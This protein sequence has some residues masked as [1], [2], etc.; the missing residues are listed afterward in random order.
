M[1]QVLHLYKIS[2]RENG[3]LK[4]VRNEKNNELN[5]LYYELRCCAVRDIWRGSTEACLF[6]FRDETD[7]AALYASGTNVSTFSAWHSRNGTL[8]SAKG[9]WI[10]NQVVKD[11]IEALQGKDAIPCV[12]R[13]E[14]FDIPCI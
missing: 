1:G 7:H 5:L 14:I 12:R 10:Q 3:W 2:G 11:G 6:R 9:G 13:L 8:A 4:T